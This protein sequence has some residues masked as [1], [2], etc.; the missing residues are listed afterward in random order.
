MAYTKGIAEEI[1]Y[2][3]SMHIVN[4]VAGKIGVRNN[5]DFIAGIGYNIADKDVLKLKMAVR[6]EG[7][8][9]I[10]E[11]KKQNSK[12][13]F[14]KLV[15]QEIAK[16]IKAYNLS[17]IISPDGDLIDPE[18][19]ESPLEKCQSE[20][21]KLKQENQQLKSQLQLIEQEKIETAEIVERIR[22]KFI[23]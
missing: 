9:K 14:S 21:E 10:E 22:E 16:V 20:L 15:K 6:Q 11:L 23:K 1:G 7:I 17:D 19:K 3:V 8:D 12:V 2:S 18:Q 4:E 13:M 5:T